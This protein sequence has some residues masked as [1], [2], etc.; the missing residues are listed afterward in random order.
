VAEAATGSMGARRLGRACASTTRITYFCSTGRMFSRAISTP[1]KLA[2]PIIEI[3]PAGNVVHSWGD[4]KQLD[5][6]L[7]S[8]AFDK[9]NN[10]W[11][12][13]APSE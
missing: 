13:S 11:V 1:E 7:H 3:D 12:G 9:D 5:P 6:R 8:C 2:P 10:F 4:L